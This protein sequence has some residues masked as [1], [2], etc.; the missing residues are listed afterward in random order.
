MKSPAWSS[1]SGSLA[2]LISVNLQE[3]EP[4]HGVLEGREEGAIQ[5]ITAPRSQEHRQS[6]LP[7]AC[8]SLQIR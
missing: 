8:W 2:A 7:V 1:L 3:Y 6:S 4:V 5:E